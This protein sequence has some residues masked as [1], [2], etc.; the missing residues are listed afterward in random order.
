YFTGIALATQRVQRMFPNA[1]NAQDKDTVEAANKLKEIF[2]LTQYK[3]LLKQDSTSIGFLKKIFGNTFTETEY[4][5]I[6]AFE[7]SKEVGGSQGILSISGDQN[8][9]MTFQVTEEELAL[10]NGG[11]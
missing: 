9:Q 1:D 5:L 3:I 7:T 8:I 6:P 10:F 4:N 2:G 11:A